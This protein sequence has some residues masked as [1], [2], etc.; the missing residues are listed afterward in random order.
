MQNV[1]FHIDIWSDLI[2]PAKTLGGFRYVF[3]VLIQLCLELGDCLSPLWFLSF[4]DFFVIAS[5]RRFVDLL[6]I[7]VSQPSIVSGK[8]FNSFVFLLHLKL[9]MAQLLAHCFSLRVSHPF[10]IFQLVFQCLHGRQHVDLALSGHTCR[11]GQMWERM[12]KAD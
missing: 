5:Y 11:R 4:T 12:S 2:L 1:I 8:F 9:F 10:G 6:S 7:H 3:V